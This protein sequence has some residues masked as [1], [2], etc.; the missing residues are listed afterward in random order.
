MYKYLLQVY[1]PKTLREIK[2]MTWN[3]KLIIL[4]GFSRK[5]VKFYYCCQYDNG[6]RAK[7]SLDQYNRMREGNVQEWDHLDT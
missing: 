4:L 6:C 1:Y 5:L 3:E 7:F 2:Q